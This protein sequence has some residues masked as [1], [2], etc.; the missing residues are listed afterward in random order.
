M[1]IYKALTIAGSDSGGG[2]G[3][4]ADLKTFQELGVYGMSVIT[5]VTA[6]NT[7]GVQGVYPLSAE[8]IEQQLAS[9]GED[10][11]PAALKTG[12]LF[13][14]DIIRVVAA[15]IQKYKWERVVVDPV[16]IAKGGASLLQQEAIDAM[17]RYL[18]PLADVI[19]PN[20]PEAEALSGIAITDSV[21]RQEAAQRIHGYGCKQVMIK[22]GH[23]DNSEQATDLL[24][25]GQTFTEFSSRRLVTR[26]THGTGCTFAAAITSGL[27]Q[28]LPMK[29]AFHLAKS[30][31][32]A[33]I[34][35][36]LNI[37]S[38][39]GPTNHWAYRRGVSNDDVRINENVATPGAR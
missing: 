23:E 32:Q 13:S 22:G 16:M 15:A 6:Q 29:A 26:H 20:I 1:S 5:A 34:A 24:Y 28:G 3:I 21:S 12:M 2:A 27:A 39:H 4:Q 25:D 31:I 33:A 11:T 37:G 14:G 38:G 10:L 9:I 36:P 8:A 19:T 18:M 35:E 30:F 7:L 17:I